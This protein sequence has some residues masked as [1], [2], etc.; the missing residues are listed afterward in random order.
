MMAMKKRRI[1]IIAIL[2]L[3]IWVRMTLLLTWN[4][5]IWPCFFFSRANKIMKEYLS[6]DFEYQWANTIVSKDC[7]GIGRGVYNCKKI[8]RKSVWNDWNDSV[9]NVWSLFENNHWLISLTN[10]AIE[11]DTGSMKDT[12]NKIENWDWNDF[13]I[14]F[15]NGYERID[16]FFH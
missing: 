16:W 10:L 4:R 1:I 3:I 8:Y 12:M 13:E 9:Y 5:D 7:L 11:K 14:L 6:E 15:W 2:L